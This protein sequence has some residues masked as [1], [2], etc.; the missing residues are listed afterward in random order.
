MNNYYSILGV[1][2]TASQDQIKQAYRKLAKQHHPDTGGNE[3]KFKEVNTAYQT[4]KD[5]S[6]RQEYDRPT[7]KMN[8]NPNNFDD[9]FSAFFNQHNLHRRNKDIKVAVTITLEEVSSGKEIIAN[10][11]LASGEHATATIKIHIGAENG[12]AIR[13]KGL[14]DNASSQ[15]PRGDLLV[16]INVLKHKQFDRDKDHVYTTH[17]I[18]V[19]DLI[20]GGK[21]NVQTL[22]GNTIIVN[23]PKGTQPGTIMSVSGHGLRSLRTNTTGNFYVVLK[24]KV[25]TLLNDDILTRIND[26]NDDIN[27]GA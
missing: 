8:T 10:Y 7:Q 22:L 16:F 17:E 21:I 24:G 11:M 4:L 12:E 25:P 14:G 19:I 18:S 3:T 23:V 20:L 13:Y 1:S 9:M 2:N 26:I 27:K 5:E 15:L 6:K